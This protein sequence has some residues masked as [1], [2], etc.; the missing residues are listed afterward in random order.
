MSTARVHVVTVATWSA[1]G[2]QLLKESAANHGVA[3]TV[4]G[5]EYNSRQEQA[6]K[7]HLV[8]EWL[9]S[10]LE[11]GR[12]AS[13]DLVVFVDGFDVVLRGGVD[14]MAAAWQS[15]GSPELLMSA[16][17]NC[18]PDK[19]LAPQFD[20]AFPTSRYRY[21]NSGT[22]AATAAV[23]VSLLPRDTA[24]LAVNGGDQIWWTRLFLAGG[25]VSGDGGKFVLDTHRRLAAAVYDD[26]V[27]TVLGCTAPIIHFNGDATDVTAEVLDAWR[28]AV[29]RTRGTDAT[30]LVAHVEHA[31][32]EADACRSRLP[33]EVLALPGLSAPRTRHFYNNLLAFHNARYLEI[34]VW[35]GST[36]CA[37]VCGNHPTAAVAID[38]FCHEGSPKPAFYANVAK[39]APPGDVVRVI[40]QDAFAVCATPAAMGAIFNMYMYDAAHGEEDQYRALSHYLPCLD[41]VFVYIVDDWNRDHVRAGT[42]RAIHDLRLDVVHV[43]EVRTTDDGSEVPGHL[44]HTTWWNGIYIAVLRKNATF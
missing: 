21:V 36:F 4:L 20:A 30:A 41:D 22:Y 9:K 15:Y 13:D 19:T 23:L 40:E 14:A 6:L 17:Q 3:L 37:A 24:E 18:W 29:P 2:L 1:P 11:D 33:A 25:A 44:A 28:A 5:T 12:V 34:G 8:R 42:L 43:R 31:F 32:A 26:G 39:F 10:S 38:N 35:K 27:S 7:P 16:E